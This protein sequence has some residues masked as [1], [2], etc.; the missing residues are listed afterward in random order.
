MPIHSADPATRAANPDGID[1]LAAEGVRAA[2]ILDSL[3]QSPED[4]FRAVGLAWEA[5]QWEEP[6]K[7]TSLRSRRTMALGNPE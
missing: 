1:R 5:P 7:S 6:G 4:L 2:A 3:M